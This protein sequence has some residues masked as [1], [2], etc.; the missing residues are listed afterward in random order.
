MKHGTKEGYTDEQVEI[1]NLEMQRER[2]EERAFNKRFFM[3]IRKIGS[4]CMT[5]Q[6][7]DCPTK[8]EFV[9]RDADG[10]YKD[11]LLNAMWWAWQEALKG[12]K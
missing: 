1:M 6:S 3:S 12:A 7:V 9:E 2:F 8:A 5:F 11:E 4:G 10:Y